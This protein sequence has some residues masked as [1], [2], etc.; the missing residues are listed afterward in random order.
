MERTRR[1][2]TAAIALVPVMFVLLLLTACS[3]DESGSRMDALRRNRALWQAQGLEDYRFVEKKSCFCYGDYLLPTRVDVRDGE[4]V[5][6]EVVADGRLMPAHLSLTVDQVFNRIAQAIAADYDLLEVT[7]DPERGFPTHLEMDPGGGVADAGFGVDISDLVTLEPETSCQPPP[8]LDCECTAEFPAV[9]YHYTAWSE[10]GDVAA[11][12]CVVLTITTTPGSD[13]PTRD[14][15]GTRCIA[16]RCLADAGSAH[17]GAQ[18]VGGQIDADGRMYLDL[19]SGT[20]DNNIFLD[21]VV[22]ETPAGWISGNW[23]ESHITGTVAH[24]RFLLD[25][26]YLTA[27]AP[28][29]GTK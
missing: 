28:P 15:T 16:V 27:P 21:A 2:P 20:A 5:R 18:P 22:E 10:V 29:S 11:T 6:A 25:R 7:Y 23:G 26:S 1:H 12:G 17:H 24:G 8:P 9:A 4:P 19:N 13:P 14:V 3:D